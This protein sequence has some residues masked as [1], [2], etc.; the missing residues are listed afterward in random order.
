MKRGLKL[1]MPNLLKNSYV[2]YAVF[3]MALVN[4]LGY[5]VK[6]DYNSVV[7]FVAVGVL[8]NYF[9]KNMTVNLLLA[10]VVTAMVAVREHFL[11]GF[12]DGE[13]DKKDKK[14]DKKDKKNKKDKKDKKD[15][16][17]T[18]GVGCED[19]SECKGEGSK[20]IQGM[21]KTGEG[22][23]QRNVPS[24]KPANLNG[25]DDSSEGNRIDY[26]ST[27]EQA[28]DNLQN[29]L[30]SDGMKGLADETKKL[31]SQQKDLMQSLNSMAPVLS[32]AKQTLDNLDLP[33]AS[34]LTSMLKNLNG[35]APSLK[36]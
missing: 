4:V 3:A 22:M 11:E 16:V 25:D 10:I 30:G 6:Q 32:S 31:V 13:K 17:E 21:C 14:K 12:E 7:L 19:D 28:Y 24:S 23:G 27:L 18:M 35:S 15:E 1:K 29:M 8:S 33:N 9:T 5:L 2:L 20:C 26:A 36:K 34:D